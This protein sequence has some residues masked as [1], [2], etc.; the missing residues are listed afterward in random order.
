MTQQMIVANPPHA[1]VNL[2]HWQGDALGKRVSLRFHTAFTD[3][4]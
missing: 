2:G 1:T 4:S 3:P